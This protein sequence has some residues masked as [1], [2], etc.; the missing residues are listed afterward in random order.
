M[1]ISAEVTS[2][3][4][5]S[6]SSASVVA[7]AVVRR[8]PGRGHALVI[9]T[10][11]APRIRILDAAVASDSWRLVGADGLVRGL[12]VVVGLGGLELVLAH[13]A[14][15][16]EAA[17]VDEAHAGHDEGGGGADQ[18]G[19]HAQ[20]LDQ[21]GQQAGQAQA[22]HDD[23]DGAQQSGEVVAPAEEGDQ[24]VG[25]DE[26]VEA[27]A[28]EG[29]VEEEVAHGDL[30]E[31]HEEIERAAQEEEGGDD[32]LL[33]RVEGEQA[34]QHRGEE[35]E[36]TPPDPQQRQQ[37]SSACVVCVCRVC[38]VCVSCVVCVVCRVSCVSCVS[39]VLCRV[40]RTA[41]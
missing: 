5:R 1:Q 40:C 11:R 15:P 36:P 18:E 17:A 9:T 19:P 37:P 12:V 2:S 21:E 39:C 16:A 32:H 6:S 33:H 10:A 24:G 31:P 8:R 34:E 13:D 30:D 4:T 3:L 20:V 28:D 22:P 26:R 25:R 38:V 41:A 35:E 14:L 29:V 7:P 23:V 27:R